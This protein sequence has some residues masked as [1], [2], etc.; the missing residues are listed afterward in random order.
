[1][2]ED[3]GEKTE[4]PTP[5][6]LQEAREKGQ[7]AKSTD[8]SGAIDLIGAAI[9][10]SLMGAWLLGMMAASLRRVLDFDDGMLHPSEAT[11]LLV[12]LGFRTLLFMTPVML[13]MA[14]VGL[15]SQIIQVGFLIN[16]EAITL[17]FGRMNPVKGV[18]NQLGRKN[19]VKS[20]LNT[21]KLSIVLFIGWKFIT[22]NAHELASLPV[23]PAA[24]G[25]GA[26]GWLAVRLAVW[27]LVML[28]ALGAA[29]Y[30]FQR[31]QHMQEL[32]MTKDQVK[33][34]RR[35]MDGDPQV[36]ARR[37]R[38]ARQMSLQRVS[39]QVPKADV[40]V[41]NPTHYSI[42]IRYDEKTMRAPRVVA[43]GVDFMALRIR[44]V[45]M[46]HKVP[47]VERPPLARALYASVEEGQEIDPE[48]Y[49]AVAEVLAFV[50]R[51]EKG[52]A[53]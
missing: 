52:A 1:M 10:I 46:M 22:A 6:K 4:A 12:V 25:M 18:Q 16:S 8:L 34:E 48:F 37:M 50:Y 15:I 44:Q 11:T 27:L 51:L 39:Q 13:L 21:L 29:D 9:V 23:L 36:K 41:T 32:R 28:L 43:K 19:L 38:I 20:L 33:D 49:E 42:A 53:A 30:L 35:S 26:L 17:N 31:W 3:L 14:L 45:A 40:I 2:A 24:A 47:I 5:R 7:I